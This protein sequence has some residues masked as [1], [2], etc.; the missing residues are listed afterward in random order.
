M[1]TLNPGAK[2]SC[3]LTVLVRPLSHHRIE[4]SNLMCI[5]TTHGT[6]RS[7][8]R[9]S[10]I[11]TVGSALLITAATSEDC[12]RAQLRAL[13]D[14]VN[15]RQIK[16]NMIC[17]LGIVRNILRRRNRASIS[18]GKHVKLFLLHCMSGYWRVLSYNAGTVQAF[19]GQ[20]FHA[21]I[22]K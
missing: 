8:I 2:G 10:R 11:P 18:G 15:I 16:R 5:S 21:T 13:S 12:S 6:T 4:T 9:Y 17:G 19:S 22:W 7:G 3:S 14:A 20:V 1:N